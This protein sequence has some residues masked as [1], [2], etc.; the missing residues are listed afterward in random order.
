MT[1]LRVIEQTV[2]DFF[3]DT[4]EYKEYKEKLEKLS[5]NGAL[6]KRV[7]EMREANFRL[8]SEEGADLMDKYDELTNAFEDVIN[9]ALVTEFLEA[10]A[11]IVKLVQEF[12]YN[13]T[14]GLEFK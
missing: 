11:A 6:L 4:K 10:E 7:N 14:S 1:D 5:Q 2:I 8:Q 13:V 9:N 12:Y 3:V